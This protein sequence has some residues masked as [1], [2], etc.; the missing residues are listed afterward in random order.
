MTDT[1]WF[2]GRLG[3]LVG[4]CGILGGWLWTQLAPVPPINGGILSGAGTIIGM[5]VGGVVFACLEWYG[6]A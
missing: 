4:G 6:A 1:A 3:L 5:A 2:W